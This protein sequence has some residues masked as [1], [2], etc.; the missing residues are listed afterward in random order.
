MGNIILDVSCLPHAATD[1]GAVWNGC[2]APFP[3]TAASQEEF[4]AHF[5]DF[6]KECFDYFFRPGA[7]GSDHISAEDYIR[8][9]TWFANFPG[10][11]GQDCCNVSS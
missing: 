11:V 5:D 6:P 7:S 2:F 8:F 9:M 10:G 1:Y 3:R 4:W